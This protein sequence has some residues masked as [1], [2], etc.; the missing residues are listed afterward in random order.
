VKAVS[1]VPKLG[2]SLRALRKK[3]DWTLADVAKMTGLSTSTISK[4]ERNQ[5]S[6]TYDKLVQLSQGLGVD[7]MTF[8]DGALTAQT[9]DV[10]GN[11]RS[12]NRLGEGHA[13]ETNKYHYLYLSTD[14]LKKKSIPMLIDIKARSL[15]EFGPLHKHFGEEFAF[16]VEGSVMFHTEHYSPVILKAGESA[17]YDG[18]M[19]HGFIALG[20]G[21]CRILTVCS[22]PPEVAMA[23]PTIRVD[24][25]EPEHMLRKST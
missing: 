21:P 15:E 19:G 6:L 18:G 8:F 23:D 3:F 2:S 10:P 14:I 11:R 7:I 9:T 5:L 24:L 22:S 20:D 1:S 13:V 4:A 12:L 25:E 17:F 16:V